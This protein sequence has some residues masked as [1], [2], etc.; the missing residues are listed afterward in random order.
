MGFV[1]IP[2]G[3]NLIWRSNDKFRGRKTGEDLRES[4]V[5]G[6]AEGKEVPV[7]GKIAL[8]VELETKELGEKFERKYL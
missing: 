3:F 7:G 8:E 6:G 2:S 5:R 1:R 4:A